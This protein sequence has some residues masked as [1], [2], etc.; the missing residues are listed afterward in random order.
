MSLDAVQPVRKLP[1]VEWPT[2]A[3]FAAIYAAFLTLTWFHAAFPLWL[4]MP[5]AAWTASWWGSAQHEALHGHPTRLRD[6]NTALATPPIW[7]WLPFERYRASHLAHHRD[8]RLTDPLDDPES[9]Y[10][11]PD[12]W[13]R[14]GRL[15]R[16]LILAQTT[17]LGRLIV[18]PAWSMAAF[19]RDEWRVA[20]RDGE[21][22]RVWI[23]HAIFVAA[24]LGWAVGVCGLPFWQ[25]AVGFVYCGTSLALVR[26]FAEHKARDH[27]DQRTAI[28]ERAPVFGLLF[29]H[30]NLHVVHH[31]W[32]TLPWYRLPE[33][34]AAHREALL[35]ENGGLVYDGYAD[36]FRRFFL[37]RHDA[38]V[39]PRGR[40][41]TRAESQAGT[42]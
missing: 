29:L 4:W 5:L 17:L 19:W 40:A 24:L 2:L 23:W 30:N 11:T 31:R 7:L 38:P 10:V 15:G 20:R 8:E 16:A 13:A 26:S 41:P 28:V 1:A 12:Q 36:V 27:V 34:Y 33:V 25:Y 14:L 18:G 35:E 21:V 32:P 6:L 9:R 3:V 22:L 37:R 39:H 42:G